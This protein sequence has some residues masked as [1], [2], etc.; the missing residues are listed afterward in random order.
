MYECMH[1]CML[2]Y[3][4]KYVCM[5]TC[6]YVHGRMGTLRLRGAEGL[7][8]RNFTHIFPTVLPEFGRAV[9]PKDG[10]LIS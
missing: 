4:C 8:C 6:M 7:I 1:A 10:A 3:V 9:A 5:Y 2:M